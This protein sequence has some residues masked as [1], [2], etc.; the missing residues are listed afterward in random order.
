MNRWETIAT[1]KPGRPEGDFIRLIGRAPDDRRD[2]LMWLS[3]DVGDANRVFLQ[4]HESGLCLNV[5]RRRRR[6]SIA[7]RGLL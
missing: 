5:E 7:A 3:K 2:G 1:P 4:L 6:V